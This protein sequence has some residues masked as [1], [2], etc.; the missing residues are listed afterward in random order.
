[1]PVFLEGVLVSDM[2]EPLATD[3]RGTLKQWMSN[4][5]S[6]KLA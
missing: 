2:T 3:M 5:K 1:M 4:C 6:L